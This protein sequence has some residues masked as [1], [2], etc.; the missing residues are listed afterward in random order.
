MVRTS[1]PA[2]HQLEQRIGVQVVAIIGVLAAA[3]DREHPKPQHGG[4]AA[5]RPRRTA[6]RHSRMQSASVSAKPSRRSAPPLAQVIA[7]WNER[8][9]CLWPIP[10]TASSVRHPDFQTRTKNKLTLVPG[11]PCSSRRCWSPVRLRGRRRLDSGSWRHSAP[12]GHRQPGEKTVTPCH[13][14]RTAVR[15]RRFARARRRC[16][17]LL[18]S[19]VEPGRSEPVGQVHADVSTPALPDIGERQG[20]TPSAAEDIVKRNAAMQTE[21]DALRG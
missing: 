10:R 1:T 7:E 15:F 13:L 8:Y 3:G 17:P 9:P 5:D 6:S 20:S 14:R 4:Q 21:A 2:D 11:P 16:R 12:W 18:A 19:P